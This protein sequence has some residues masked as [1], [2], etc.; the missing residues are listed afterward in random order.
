MRVIA[1][2]PS[3]A[4]F[5]GVPACAKQRGQ[6]RLRLEAIQHGISRKTLFELALDRAHEDLMEVDRPLRVEQWA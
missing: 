6:L 4:R 3:L 2:L 1:I 5:T